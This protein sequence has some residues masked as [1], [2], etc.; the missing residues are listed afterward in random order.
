MT[1]AER[2]GHWKVG[3]AESIERRLPAFYFVFALLLTSVL[4][5][6]TPPFF[7]PDEPSQ[8][9]RALALLH[10]EILPRMGADQ[11]GGEVDTGA[12]HAMDAMDSIRMRWEPQSP[13]FHDRRYGP[14]SV[15]AQARWADVRWSGEKRIAGFG[16]TA[17][18]PPG[19]Y[20]PA[21]AGWKVAEAANLT[22]FASL[23]L[24]R[25]LTAF[26]AALLGW[27]ALRWSGRGAWMLLPALL[28][29]SELFLQ[30]TCSQDAL[31]LPVAALGVALICRALNERRGLGD[32]EL[33]LAAVLFALCAM[34]K[35]PFA[36]LGVIIF[37]PAVELKEWGWKLWL[38]HAASFT[39]LVVAC[40]AWWHLVARFGMDTADEADPARQVA[41]LASHPI[42]ASLAIGRGTAEAAWDFVHRGLYV[43]G[44][45][46]LLPHHGAALVLSVCLLVIAWRA[47]SVGV[48]SW[49]ARI[50]I[51]IA[52][53]VPLIGISIAEYLIWT[54]PGLR[55]VYGVQ[56]RYWLPVLPA[57]MLLVTS[58]RRREELGAEWLLPVATILL[59]C[60]AC[61]L[62]WM[63]ASAFYRAGLMQAVRINLR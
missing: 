14:V 8:S 61:T 20:L 11:A 44:W 35:P 42:A 49:R 27:L 30:A 48:R 34:A 52:V 47:P 38:K 37:V 4:C 25:W 22:I 58:R 56:P 26:T 31:L 12:V 46:D 9:L 36:A 7:G 40:A 17:T 54:P 51:L 50:L 45:N 59:A 57:M 13:D 18:Y 62:P 15:E 60:V 10:G 53:I 2:V 28:L 6:T 24:A 3:T 43:V 21:M 16:N 23:R 29:P 55:T 33:A 41:F 19:L 32:G 5:W 1:R 39:A 63:E